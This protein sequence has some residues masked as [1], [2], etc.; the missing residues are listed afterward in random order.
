MSQQS[1][2]A[3]KPINRGAEAHSSEG[4]VPPSLSPHHR[5]Q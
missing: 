4:I 3:H 2:L 5:S 1:A